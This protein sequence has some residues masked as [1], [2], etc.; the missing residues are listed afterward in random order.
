[1]IRAITVSPDAILAS[2]LERV[3]HA[4]GAIRIER[5]ADS[6][7]TEATLIRI[8][9]CHAPHLVFLNFEAETTA[10]EVAERIQLHAPG[11]QVIAI[12][13]RREEAALLAALRSGVREFLTAPF[14]EEEF[15]HAMRRV[16]MQ[17][18]RVPPTFHRTDAVFAFVPAKPGSG[19]STVAVNTAL[20]I[21]RESSS[22]VLLADLDVYSGVVS[23]MLQ[24]RHDVSTILDAAELCGRL[25][26]NLWS[27]LVCRI[28]DLDLL[29]TARLK[30]GQRLDNLS[31][32]Q[33]LEYARRS[34]STVCLDL[35]GGFED[36][37][38]EALH[39][40]KRILVVCTPELCSLRLAR[41]KVH[42]LRELELHDKVSLVL[43]RTSR[44]TDLPVQEVERIVEM[45]VLISMPNDY[46]SVRR[47]VTEGQPVKTT[48]EL[49]TRFT[50][51]ARTLLQ[52]EVPPVRQSRRFLEQFTLAPYR[53]L[54]GDATTRQR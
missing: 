14:S 23:F 38:V 8:L 27:Q 45:P 35:S 15:I 36:Y 26:E 10:G 17:L 33:I 18:E 54:F 50:E 5:K 32:R 21:S 52:K 7:P 51:L 19:A 28:K 3:A 46:G 47:A 24:L 29:A 31:I 25:D 39:E 6:Y 1:M 42:M 4:T 13:K 22:G 20:A 9:R 11:T 37:S 16:V 2:E 44:L 30:T 34:Y 40:A 48:S 41:D 43:N 49:G 12:H 53:L